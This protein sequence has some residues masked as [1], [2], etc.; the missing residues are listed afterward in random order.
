MISSEILQ[1]AMISSDFKL[2]LMASAF[3]KL[4]GCIRTSR[5][6]TAIS[7][8]LPNVLVLR[9]EGMT[10]F[11]SLPITGSISFILFFFYETGFISSRGRRDSDVEVP[12]LILGVV[13]VFV[14]AMLECLILPVVE[15]A[16]EV[17]LTEVVS[18]S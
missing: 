15:F 6:L 8:L 4:L 2:I 11:F 5:N 17:L 13:G 14:L 3:I 7:N 1:R 10:L 9:E 16:E 18:E 12:P